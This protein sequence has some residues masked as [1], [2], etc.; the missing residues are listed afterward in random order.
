MFELNSS[1]NSLFLSKLVNVLRLKT[2]VLKPIQDRLN[3]I[4]LM[5]L[6]FSDSFSNLFSS[7]IFFNFN[8]A[9][10]TMNPIIDSDFER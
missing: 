10:G 4:S 7:T 1:I 6:L 8:K 3:T 5:P 9:V 2:Q